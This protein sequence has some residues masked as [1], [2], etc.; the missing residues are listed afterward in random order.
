MMKILDKNE[1]NPFM[2]EPITKCFDASNKQEAVFIA[3]SDFAKLYNE[4]KI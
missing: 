4:K 2:I 1:E 3:V